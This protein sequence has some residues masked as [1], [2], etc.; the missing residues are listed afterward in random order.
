MAK[1]PDKRSDNSESQTQAEMRDRVI[2]LAF[3]GDKKLFDEFLR[4]LGEATPDGVDVILRGSAVTGH[5]WGSDE[6]F[7]ADVIEG[8][9][10]VSVTK[11]IAPLLKDIEAKLPAGYRIDVGGAVEESDKANAALIAVAYSPALAQRGE[12]GQAYIEFDGGTRQVTAEVK[13]PKIPMD[14]SP[15]SQAREARAQS[16]D[17]PSQ[18]ACQGET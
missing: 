16:R 1:Q 13:A 11:E 18:A 9:Q 17:H 14:V 7:D 15:L 2:R 8:E 12:K 10:G 3:G 5:K 4:V 6:P